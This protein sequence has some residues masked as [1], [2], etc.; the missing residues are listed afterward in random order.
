MSAGGH[1]L[2]GPGLGHV[3]D[4]GQQVPHLAGTEAVHRRHV[5]ATHTNLIDLVD[6]PGLH[7]AQRSCSIQVAVHHS[8]GR[9]H[10]AVLVKVAVEDQGLEWSVGVPDWWRGPLHH[11]VQQLGHPFACLGADVKNVLGGNAEDLLNL[12]GV[13]VGLGGRQVDFVQRSHDLQVV[14][15]R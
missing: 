11:G 14:L 15:Q 3:L 10:P 13:P 9:H 5:R 7:E 4:A 8:D 6:R 1:R 2:S 12:L